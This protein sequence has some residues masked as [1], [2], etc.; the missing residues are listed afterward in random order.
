MGPPNT[1]DNHHVIYAHLS[2]S[3]LVFEIEKC[4]CTIRIRVQASV[5]NKLF[6]YWYWSWY[7]KNH[8]N[9]KSQRIIQNLFLNILISIVIKS[10]Y[11]FICGYAM[12]FWS[13]VATVVML[14]W[15]MM[16]Q[17]WRN[18]IMENNEPLELKLVYLVFLVTTN[19]GK[20]NMV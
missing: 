10:D 3:W 14:W 9:Q 1:C 2:T 8:A 15:W 18:N 20:F 7:D 5:G 17:N 6:I 4:C 16:P 11:E 12:M 19:T 13:C